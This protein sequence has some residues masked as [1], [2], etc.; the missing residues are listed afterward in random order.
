MCDNQRGG[1]S[2]KSIS[3]RP[4]EICVGAVDGSPCYGCS[5]AIGQNSDWDGIVNTRL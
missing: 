2:T 3:L 4:G 1:G 5:V